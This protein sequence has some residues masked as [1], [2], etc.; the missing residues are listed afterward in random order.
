M[1]VVNIKVSGNLEQ[2]KYVTLR[3][4]GLLQAA[5]FAC[6]AG[7]TE[8][9][10]IVSSEKARAQAE[11]VNSLDSQILAALHEQNEHLRAIAAHTRPVD[12]AVAVTAPK[13]GE[14]LPPE[15][16]TPTSNLARL[17]KLA[18]MVRQDG[19]YLRHDT[20]TLA[21]ELGHAKCYRGLM[22]N[23]A[24]LGWG[25][26]IAC[27]GGENSAHLFELAGQLLRATGGA[28]RA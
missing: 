26:V 24:S 14:R 17:R 6:N 9:D 8:F 28:Y 20:M 27:K 10:V 3:L 23:I 19:R 21:C 22:E 4:I 16:V 2:S 13:V 18:H 1:S 11:P 5:G 12:M 25:M 15:Q 7:M